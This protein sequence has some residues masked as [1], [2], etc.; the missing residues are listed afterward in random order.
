MEVFLLSISDLLTS[1]ASWCLEQGMGASFLRHKVIAN[2]LANVETPGYKRQVV[3]FEE[4]LNEALSSS[5]KLPL[6]LTHPLHRGNRGRFPTKP[7]VVRDYS[8]T[9]RN[10]GNNVDVETE[11]AALAANTLYHQAVAQQLEAY[12]ARLRTAIY[13]GRR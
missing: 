7:E 2:N 11:T 1:P 5:K 12:F 13:E 10:D 4:Q 8:T 3:R 6:T 9:M